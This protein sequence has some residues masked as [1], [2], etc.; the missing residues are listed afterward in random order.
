MTDV[1]VGSNPDTKGNFYPFVIFDENREWLV[2][3]HADGELEFAE[4]YEPVG[5]ALI[6]WNTVAEFAAPWMQDFEDAGKALD[7]LG[8]PREAE[9]KTLTMTMRIGWLVARRGALEG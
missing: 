8:V 1:D 4:G 5:A 7:T 9:G 3:C 6:W 2:K